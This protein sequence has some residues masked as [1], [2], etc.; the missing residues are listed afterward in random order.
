MAGCRDGRRRRPGHP[1]SAPTDV[2]RPSGGVTVRAGWSSAQLGWHEFR[3]RP[4]PYIPPGLP[5]PAHRGDSWRVVSLSPDQPVGIGLSTAG[6]CYDAT[7]LVRR[8][9]RTWRDRLPRVGSEPSPLPL[10]SHWTID[11]G[12]AAERATVATL[13]QVLAQRPELRR[14]LDEPRRV[15]RLLD[16]M[17][18]DPLNEVLDADT[19]SRRRFEVI[20]TLKRLGYTHRIGGQRP[21]SEP[22]PKI[23]EVVSR[24]E[25]DLQ[26][27]P[28]TRDLGIEPEL[29]R[30]VVRE[31]YFVPPWPLRAL[32]D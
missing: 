22:M 4:D 32:L 19:L 9:R 13:F 29:I 27:N 7:E 23:E 1:W 31:R 10:V 14:R 25:Q 15:R 18:S 8:Q 21:P 11:A 12:L 2:L 17:R 30:E 16:E 24:V 26:H 5:T 3:N 28:F 20:G 6:R